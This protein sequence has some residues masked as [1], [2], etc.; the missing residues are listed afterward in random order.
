MPR[1]IKKYHGQALFTSS[2][3]KYQLKNKIINI[4]DTAATRLEKKYGVTIKQTIFDDL[5]IT[6]SGYHKRTK[7]INYYYNTYQF[8][9]FRMAS[10]SDLSYYLN[11]C[12][13]YM[14]LCVL[15]QRI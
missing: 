6:I 2:T 11:E 4:V 7:K 8:Y 10:D 13:E 5:R 15:G 1:P 14:T 9:E 12:L 3:S